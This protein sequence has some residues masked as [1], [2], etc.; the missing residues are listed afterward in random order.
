[1]EVITSVVDPDPIRI[2]YGSRRAEL[3]A[4]L[5]AWT[6]A[7]C[8]F[9]SKKGEKKIFS[10]NFQFL[11]IKTL[12]PDP[13]SLEMLDP[14]PYPDPVSMNPDPQLWLSPYEQW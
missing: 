7:N 12:D 13:D 10:C 6:L 14:D 2:G 9:G 4:S 5:V 8:N 11:V 1:M 3:N